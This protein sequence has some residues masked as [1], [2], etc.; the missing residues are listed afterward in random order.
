[1]GWCD[2]AQRYVRS[3][4]VCTEWQVHNDWVLEKIGE[5]RYPF[6]GSVSLTLGRV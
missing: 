5:R 2:Y 4:M 1:M 6:L 3:G